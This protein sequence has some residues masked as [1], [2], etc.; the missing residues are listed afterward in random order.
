MNPAPVKVSRGD[1]AQ[2]PEAAVQDPR[3]AAD[4]PGPH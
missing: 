1:T 2:S 4:E 3:D